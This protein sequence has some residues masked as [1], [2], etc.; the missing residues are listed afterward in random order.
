M[1]K[2]FETLSGLRARA[3]AL[4]SKP[5]FRVAKD[6]DGFIPLDVRR[7]FFSLPVYLFCD[8]LFNLCL[9]VFLVIG[10]SSGDTV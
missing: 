8:L 7:E 10:Q 6:L 5:H 4:F 1:V 3:D 9:A 2:A